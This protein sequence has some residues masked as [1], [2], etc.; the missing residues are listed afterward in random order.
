M[1]WIAERLAE[2]TASPRDA[3]MYRAAAAQIL[4]MAQHHELPEL[5]RPPSHAPD[6]DAARLWRYFAHRGAMGQAIAEVGAELGGYVSARRL[7]GS[8]RQPALCGIV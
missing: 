5:R 4:A 8:E 6:L 2:R 7:I 1:L 3:A